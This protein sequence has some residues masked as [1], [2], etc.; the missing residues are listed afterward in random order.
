M[1]IYK[2][3]LQVLNRDVKALGRKME[4][5][6]KEGGKGGRAAVSI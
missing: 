5:L 4:K 3:D 1:I 6:I 2:N